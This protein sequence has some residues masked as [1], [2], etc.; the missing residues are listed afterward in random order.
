MSLVIDEK[1]FPLRLMQD[2]PISD[3]RLERIREA[4]SMLHIEREPNGTL[5]IRLNIGIAAQSGPE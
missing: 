3:E 1:H 5:C 4:N 2:E